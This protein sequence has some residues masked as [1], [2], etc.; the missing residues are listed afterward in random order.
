MSFFPSDWDDEDDDDFNGNVEE[1]VKEFE[2][3]NRDDFSPRELLEIYRYYSMDQLFSGVEGT[4][5]SHMK[6]VLELG[7]S[8]FPYIPVFT[9]H[10][11]EIL[12]GEKNYRLA[13][14][15][16]SKQK[17]TMPLNPHCFSWK[18]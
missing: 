5:R 13:R 8:Q 3:R 15:Y 7:M 16:I 11:V 9:L 17:N 1:L 14:K 10:M 18:L 2:N 6:M 4:G 12:M